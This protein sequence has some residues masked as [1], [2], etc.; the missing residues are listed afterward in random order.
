MSPR[1]RQT[2]VTKRALSRSCWMHIDPRHCKAPTPKERK[3]EEEGEEEGVLLAE[4]AN[5][6]WSLRC[7]S[8]HSM[9]SDLASCLHA[10]TQFISNLLNSSMSARQGGQGSKTGCNN[11][12]VHLVRMRLDVNRSRDIEVKIEAEFN[13][14]LNSHALL[15]TLLPEG[16]WVL[17]CALST[18][19]PWLVQEGLPLSRQ[20]QLMWLPPSQPLLLLKGA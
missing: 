13:A 4:F 15:W 8:G 5:S 20:L 2:S 16:F 7:T 10:S 11:I 19:P 17:R 12:R 9:A 14:I 1:A 6:D 3:E 18:H